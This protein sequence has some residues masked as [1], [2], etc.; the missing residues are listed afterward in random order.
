MEEQVKILLLQGDKI[1]A[2]EHVRQRAGVC[3]AESLRYVNDLESGLEEKLQHTGTNMTKPVMP[4]LPDFVHQ[5]VRRLLPKQKIMAIKEVR[6]RM[7]CSLKEAKDY[8]EDVQY[9]RRPEPPEPEPP[10]KFPYRSI[11]DPWNV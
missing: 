1:G 4:P 3:L 6:E 7:I 9:G 10:P 8:V 2:I 5:I 11:D